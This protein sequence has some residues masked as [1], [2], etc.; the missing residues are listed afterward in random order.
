MVITARRQERFVGMKTGKVFWLWQRNLLCGD[1]THLT[2]LA[3]SSCASI[4][5]TLLR[6][7]FCRSGSN[8]CTVPSA[9]ATAAKVLQRDF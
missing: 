8:N 9:V 1:N 7:R 2:Q 6:S 4:R 3:Q 5:R